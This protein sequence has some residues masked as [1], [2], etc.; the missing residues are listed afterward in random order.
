M[1]ANAKEAVK[2]GDIKYALEILSSVR[3]DQMSY[4]EARTMMA[5]IYLNKQKDRKKYATCFKE[6]VEKRPT[7]ESCLLLGDAFMKIQEPLEAISVYQAALKSYSDQTIFV[8]KIGNA[9]VMMHDYAK[10]TSY[11][12]AAIMTATTDKQQLQFDLGQLLFRLKK[13]DDANNVI[14][15][16]I[17]GAIGKFFA[18]IEGSEFPTSLEV[19]LKRLQG[20]VFKA[21]EQTQMASSAFVGAK[22]TLMRY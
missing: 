13:Y 10:A 19:N 11:Y 3:P 16:G 14:Q 20:L 22:D 6:V 17:D 18:L 5:D 1:I 4:L 2:I 21:L 7:V 8:G 9:Y 12:K 15:E